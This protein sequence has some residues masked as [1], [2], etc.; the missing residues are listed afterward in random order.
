MN[1]GAPLEHLA[2]P[3]EGVELLELEL[4]VDAADEHVG[5][6]VDLVLQPELAAFP[7]L[8]V[9]HQVDHRPRRVHQLVVLVVFLLE[10]RVRQVLVAVLLLLF[11]LA[12]V[13]VVAALREEARRG[14]V[15]HHGLL[16]AAAVVVL[17]SGDA[18]VVGGVLGGGAAHDGVDL[19]VDCGGEEL[20]VAED[21]EDEQPRLHG[22]RLGPHR[23]RFR[24]HHRHDRRY[25]LLQEHG[26]LALHLSLFSTN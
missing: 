5:D 19:V 10:Q 20:P 23:R 11:L 7:F 18:T 16:A 17:H 9:A 24:L 12:G 1:L 3:L 26:R 2:E 13:I 14:V 4:L 22:A 8:G 25:H 15:Q 21:A 6:V